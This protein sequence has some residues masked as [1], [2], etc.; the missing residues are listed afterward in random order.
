MAIFTPLSPYQDIATQTD[1]FFKRTMAGLETLMAR[2]QPDTGATIREMNISK[3]ILNTEGLAV[4]IINVHCLN[5]KYAIGNL[6]TQ[7]WQPRYDG[8]FQQADVSPEYFAQSYVDKTDQ[9]EFRLSVTQF[10]SKA[11]G[12]AP[13]KWSTTYRINQAD[14]DKRADVAIKTKEMTSYLW[15]DPA[16]V[17]VTRKFFTD[18]FPLLT[19]WDPTPEDITTQT[20]FNK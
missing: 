6:I 11:M 7:T 2:T 9:Y 17:L 13:V 16:I 19:T 18:V 15:Q 5:E 1:T 14:L 4:G 12:L 20:I 8:N 3:L 10:E